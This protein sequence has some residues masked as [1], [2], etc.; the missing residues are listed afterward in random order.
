[1]SFL[2]RQFKKL[3]KLQLWQISLSTMAYTLPASKCWKMQDIPWQQKKYAESN[4]QIE[5]HCHNSLLILNLDPKNVSFNAYTV[6]KTINKL[7]KPVNELIMP[8]SCVCGDV[9]KSFY[10]KK[11]LSMDTYMSSIWFFQGLLCFNYVC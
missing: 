1:M 10:I 11:I 5:Q 7:I 9:W 2:C 3:Q 8:N 6:Q 4:D